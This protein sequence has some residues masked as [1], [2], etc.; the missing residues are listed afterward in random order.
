MLSFH[1]ELLDKVFL[2]NVN[3]F[4]VYKDYAFIYGDYGRA[5]EIHILS[6]EIPEKPTH[7]Q[8]ISFQNVIVKVEIKMDT[9]YVAE[10]KRAIHTFDLS[11]ISEPKRVNS[12]VLL[13]YD[14]YDMKIIGENAILAMNWEGIG[15]VDLNLSDQIQ[16][17]QKIKIENGCVEYF[18]SFGDRFFT[19]S[20]LKN[21][22]FLYEISIINGY[23]EIKNKKEFSDFNPSSVFCGTSEVVLYGEFKKG[24]NNRS[25]IL[26]LDDNLQPLGEPIRLERSPIVCFQLSDGNFLFGFDYSYVLLDKTQCTIVPLF[27]QFKQ[28]SSNK[29]IEIASNSDSRLEP[30]DTSTLVSMDSLQNAHKQGDFFFALHGNHFTSFRILENSLFQDI[31]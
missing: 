5:Y 9:L 3:Q 11:N 15:L 23:L 17:V 27:A 29:Y 24:K 22:P 12:F 14:I 1:L 4:V 25:G 26:L 10:D 2:K 18:V 19:V 8:S 16:P 6:L 28:K 20:S 31:V 13:G 30:Q 21:D 7:V